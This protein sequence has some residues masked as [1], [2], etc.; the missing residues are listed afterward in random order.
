MSATEIFTRNYVIQ[1]ALKFK[2]YRRKTSP[3]NSITRTIQYDGILCSRNLILCWTFPRNATSNINNT[4]NNLPQLHTR[5]YC[6]QHLVTETQHMGCKSAGRTSKH[7]DFSY[8]RFLQHKT[9]ESHD[10]INAQSQRN[11]SHCWAILLLP[12]SNEKSTL[13]LFSLR[14]E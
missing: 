8:W 4:K 6:H 9:A 7:F 13:A 3:S 1:Q 2:S 14:M 10:I 11:I 12:Y 5:H